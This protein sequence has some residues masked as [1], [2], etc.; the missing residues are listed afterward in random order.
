MNDAI[1]ASVVI[2]LSGCIF[3]DHIDLLLSQGKGISRFWDGTE[4]SRVRTR[5]A[6][7]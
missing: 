5:Q 1:R 3:A 4:G 2:T 7:A 6:C